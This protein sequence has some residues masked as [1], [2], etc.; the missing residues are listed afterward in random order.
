MR[1]YDIFIAPTAGY[2]TEE[3]VYK[4]NFKGEIIFY[5]YTVENI[6]EFTYIIFID[7]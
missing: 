4:N 3:S 7:E 1:K 2:L 6:R 5:D